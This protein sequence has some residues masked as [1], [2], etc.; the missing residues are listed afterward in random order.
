MSYYCNYICALAY[1]IDIASVS[2][3]SLSLIHRSLT[4]ISSAYYPFVLT[5]RQSA[6]AMWLVSYW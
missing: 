1:P 2:A 5:A 6:A 4:S 3:A